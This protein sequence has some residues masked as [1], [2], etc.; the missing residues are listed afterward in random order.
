ML[1]LKYKIT[2]TNGIHARPAG[3]LVKEAGNFSCN[4]TLK[5]N[6]KEAD[7]KRIFSVMSLGVK[8]KDEITLE[9]DGDD[10]AEAYSKIQK[11]LTDNL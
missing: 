1:E 8:C 10:E 11:F 9:F 2:D 4:I 7:A 5:A 3:L 6:G